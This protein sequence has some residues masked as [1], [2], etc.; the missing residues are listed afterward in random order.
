V[1]LSPLLLLLAAMSKL[2]LFSEVI[3]LC[4]VPGP[5]GFEAVLVFVLLHF[6]L[7]VFA[8]VFMFLSRAWVVVNATFC[9]G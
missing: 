5:I 7:C 6:V 8:F 2:L 1:V 4:F 9:D 3:Q